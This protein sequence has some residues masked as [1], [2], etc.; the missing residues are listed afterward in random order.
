MISIRVP[1]FNVEQ[2][3]AA[4]GEG[5]QISSV[6]TRLSDLIFNEDLYLALAATSTLHTFGLSERVLTGE[7][8]SD[9]RWIYD[10]RFAKKSGPARAL[11]N[12]I[13]G[14]SPHGRC[15]LCLHQ[16]A[17]ALDHYLPKSAFGSLALTPANLVPIC[18]R[19]NKKKGAYSTSISSEQ[20]F[21]AYFERL[22]QLDWLQA[23]LT[24]TAYAPL[25]FVVHHPSDWTAEFAARADLH[26]NRLELNDLYSA[27]AAA[28]L[29]G[30]EFRLREILKAGSADDVRAYMNDLADSYARS[31]TMHWRSAA[32]RA[33]AASD[34]FCAGGFT[35]E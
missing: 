33:W 11:Y 17:Q 10:Q 26:F 20:P 2:V 15:P 7:E 6:S 23:I 5:N 27:N 8:N 1:A 31:P 21:H 29:S 34:W 18:D 22:S 13:V 32:F 19:C 30:I 16:A 25:R 12:A 4:C 9:I 28:E 3:L 14:A 24:E 35:P